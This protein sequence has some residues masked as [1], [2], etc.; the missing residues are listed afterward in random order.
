MQT[1]LEHD[2]ATLTILAYPLRADGLLLDTPRSGKLTATSGG[3]IDLRLSGNLALQHSE[4]LIGVKQPGGGAAYMGVEIVGDSVAADARTVAAVR[5]GI[6]ERVLV[7]EGRL[8]VLSA[9]RFRYERAFADEVYASWQQAGILRRVTLDKV[10][11]CPQCSALPTF[12]FGCQRCRS[13][14]LQQA[15]WVHHFACACVAPL[16][17][18]E[19]GPSLKCPKCQTQH[20]IAGTDFEYAPGEHL[21]QECGWK[22]RELTQVGHCLQCETRFPLHQAAEHTLEGFD[23]DQMDAL[24]FIP[25][26]E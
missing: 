16:A 3:G 19:G 21:C 23:V 22:A 26:G 2:T 4:L 18:F 8:P 14:R 13:G 20:L 1:L 7:E 15:T 6:G 17:A 11:V 24:A 10:L 25:H 12:R 9:R 5:G